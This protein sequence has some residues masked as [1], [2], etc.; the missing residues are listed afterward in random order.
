MAPKVPSFVKRSK[1]VDEVFKM[2]QEAKEVPLAVTPIN[3]VF[4]Q[5]CVQ[6]QPSTSSKRKLSQTTLD[7][8]GSSQTRS[9]RK[10]KAVKVDP[11][12]APNQLKDMIDTHIPIETIAGWA[13]MDA[14]EA[15]HAMR[16]SSAQNAFFTLRFCDDIAEKTQ[17]D[18]RLQGQ[19]AKL[20]EE[21]TTCEEK[22]NTTTAAVRRMRAVENLLKKDKDELQGE[23][24]SLKD[25]KISML[26]KVNELEAQVDAL[27]AAAASVK[28]SMLAKEKARYDEGYD[29]GIRDYM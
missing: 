27:N 8:S 9:M 21:L 24:K 4:T 18:L 17:Y 22:A 20:K 10:G 1:H 7:L 23:V 14:T 5:A 6:T 3:Q 25:E 26:E 15:I 19:V 16:F 11:S 12:T 13:K 28:S 29:E 2:E